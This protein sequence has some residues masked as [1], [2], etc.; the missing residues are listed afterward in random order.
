MPADITV[1]P[2]YGRDYKSKKSVQ[3]AWDEEKDFIMYE[4]GQHINKRDHK[5]Y[6]AGRQVWVRYGKELKKMRVA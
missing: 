6:S 3:E 5:K 2:M 1:K 4:T